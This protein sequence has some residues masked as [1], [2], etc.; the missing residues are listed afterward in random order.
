MKC[1]IDWLTFTTNINQFHL[2]EVI[3]NDSKTVTEIINF[4]IIQRFC[5]ILMPGLSFNADGWQYGTGRY[6]FK[7]KQYYEGIEVLYGGSEG[8]GIADLVC[9]NISGNGCRTYEAYHQGDFSKLLE[10]TLLV[11][12]N[13]TRIDLAVDDRDG[14][15]D[16]DQIYSMSATRTN[17]KGEIN[18]DCQWWGNFRVSSRTQGDQGTTLYFGSEL[19][20]VRIRI[21]DKAAEQGIEGHWIRTEVVLRDEKSKDAIT[22]ILNNDDA[23]QVFSRILRQSLLFLD[24]PITEFTKSHEAEQAQQHICDWWKTFL[25]NAEP[26]KLT[27]SSKKM[28]SWE[29]VKHHVEI[30]CPK[31]FNIYCQVIGYQGLK[32][33]VEC[34]QSKLTNEDKRL[35]EDARVTE[36]FGG[37]L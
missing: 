5:E 15:L 21:Y 16:I 24:C 28:K 27:G 4:G 17:R 31:N 35:I 22:Q 19:S 12:K 37:M 13:I 14:Y 26:L 32:E 9:I 34:G 3:Y 30:Q 6:S 2:Q 8:Q 33:I 7:Y 23:G 29:G 36:L 1:C 18:T 11:A 25:D 20:K 10:Y